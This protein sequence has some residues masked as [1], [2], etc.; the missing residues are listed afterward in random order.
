[1]ADPSYIVDGV[2]T[3]GEAWVAIASTTLGADTADITFTS[4]ADGSSLDW[5]QFMDL[6]VI[7][8]LRSA[9][10]DYSTTCYLNIN[11]SSTNADYALQQFV[12]NGSAAV[13]TTPGT[14]H[15]FFP[16]LIGD[17]AANPANA[18][19]AAIGH[20]F[21]INSG[22]YKPWLTEAASDLA[23]GGVVSL[24]AGSILTQAPITSLKF[25]C[26]SGSDLLDESRID[27]FGVLPRMVA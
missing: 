23:G 22:A 18:F 17:H 4:P 26:S 25:Y 5:S 14:T 1:M 6:I 11:G 15:V 16:T 12:G 20:F 7:A 3:D 21:N 27:L 13:A 24:S 2:L 8:Y 9:V 10:N 19:S